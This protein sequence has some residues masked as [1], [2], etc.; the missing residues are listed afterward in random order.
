M[1]RII[2][3]ICGLIAAAI[4]MAIAIDNTGNENGR[5]SMSPEE[6]AEAFCR[7]VATGDFAQARG[8]C[9]TASMSEYLKI[10][11]RNWSFLVQNDSTV[12]SVAKGMMDKIYFRIVGNTRDGG[13]RYIDY[14]IST[15]EGL[16]KSK[17]M[18]LKKEEGEWRV[19]SVTDRR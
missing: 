5:K 12:A 3:L 13:I 10:C 17:T 9:D 6:V 1:K 14:T 8:F 19:T 15:E 18:S 11:S 16:N 4:V 7:A 2:Y